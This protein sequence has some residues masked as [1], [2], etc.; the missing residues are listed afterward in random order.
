[1]SSAQGRDAEHSVVG[2]D[3]TLRACVDRFART[4]NGV[5]AF[6]DEGG[7]FAGLLTA[8]DVFRLLAS[9]L[10]LDDPV[11]PHVNTRPITVGTD[12]T[13]P[14][15]L[16]V[17]MSR[18]INHVPVLRPDGTLERIATQSALLQENLLHNRAVIMAGG[19]GQ[20]LRPITE[21]LPKALVEI[22]GRPMLDI[23]IERLRA[24]GILDITLCVRHLGDMIRAHAGDGRAWHVNIDYVEETEPLGTCGALSLIGEPWKDA[25]FVLNCDV[26][27]DVD[28]SSMQ[29]FHALHRAQLTVAVK[30]QHVEVPFGIVEADHE[31]V[32]RISEK[33]RL[34][35]YVNAGIYLLEPEVKN[36][37]PRGRRY[38]MTDLITDLIAR[39]AT[40][41]SFPIR[42]SWLDVGNADMLRRAR[43]ERPG[44]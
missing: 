32:L 15:I 6:V 42:T 19:E 12:T 16:R 21:R 31:R 3:V 34:R 11:R 22:D 1:V 36:A 18:G 7:R 29:R 2:P 37:V 33:P 43:G 10:S 4:R 41:C 39:D 38:D 26:L 28:L 5:V 20:R 35:F 13:S 30:D 23:M 9:G 40:V 17:M 27:S 24:A 25:A 44:E 8:G 14:E